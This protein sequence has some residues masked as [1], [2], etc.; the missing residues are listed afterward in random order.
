MADAVAASGLEG[1]FS[2]AGRTAR[3]V[4]QP[5]PTRIGG[6]GGV[7]GLV[8]YL[9]QTAITHI[10]DATHPFA[11]G[12][13]QNAIAASAQTGIPLIALE[14]PAWQPGPGDDWMTV[15]DFE[16]AA[17][18]LPGDGS[19]VFLAIGRQNLAPF[20]GRAHRWMLRFAEVASHP[21]PDA[22]LIISRGPFTVPGDTELLRRHQIRHIVAKNAGGSAARAKLDAARALG[23]PVVM[24]DRPALPPRHAVTTPDQVL[25]WL[26][27]ADRGV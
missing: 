24:I 23:L 5:M 25:R 10:V 16:S 15:A 7:A 3:P 17:A 9:R 18:S 21:M 22:T 14:R 6:F 12:I 11:A 13:S 8:D 4:A 26:H 2:Y 19:G 1:V 20:L 27:D